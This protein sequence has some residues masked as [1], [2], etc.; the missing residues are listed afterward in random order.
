M[1]PKFPSQ[2]THLLLFTRY[3]EPGTTKTRLIPTLGKQ[4]AALLQ[5]RMT[6]K[7]VESVQT[8]LLKAVDERSDL[9][10]SIYF[11]NGTVEEMYAWLGNYSYKVQQGKNLGEKMENAFRDCFVD[12]ATQTIIFGSDIPGIDSQILDTAIKTVSDDNVVIGPC[13]DGGYYLLGFTQD[14]ASRLYPELFTNMNWSTNSVF[15]TT[16]ERIHKLGLNPTTLAP[17]R[18]IDTAADLDYARELGLL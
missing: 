14:N 8:L 6:E 17:L 7:I 3:P 12:G 5:K 16:K 15:E 9:D 1:T 13:L 11:N 10:L 18:D 2:K 4:Q